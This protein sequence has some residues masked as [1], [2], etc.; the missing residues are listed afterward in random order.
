MGSCGWV[1]AL[2]ISIGTVE[3]VLKSLLPKLQ[4][5]AKNVEQRKGGITV[6]Q[7]KNEQDR[8]HRYLRHSSFI[9]TV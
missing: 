3:L 1:R 6:T 9:F 5:E 4:V 2:T 8:K 7:G